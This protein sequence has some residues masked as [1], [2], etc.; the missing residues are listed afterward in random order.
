[1]SKD[2]DISKFLTGADVTNLLSQYHQAHLEKYQPDHPEHILPQLDNSFWQNDK[3]ELIFYAGD[4]TV[5]D[6]ARQ[7]IDQN[8]GRNLYA[9]NLTIVSRLLRY[10]LSTL[11]SE[12]I[13]IIALMNWNNVHWTS[14]V[15]TLKD[16]NKEK[17]SEIY[18]GY[19][20]FKNWLRIHHPTCNLGKETSSTDLFV[21]YVTGNR[22]GDIVGILKDKK[23][24]P[25]EEIEQLICDYFIGIKKEKLLEVNEKPAQYSSYIEGDLKLI[26]EPKNLEDSVFCHFDSMHSESRETLIKNYADR[27]LSANKLGVAHAEL[28]QQSGNT[29][30]EHAVLNALKYV[31]FGLNN[32]IS[33]VDLRTA[34]NYFCSEF[35]RLFLFDFDVNTYKDSFELILTHQKAKA[36]KTPESK[37]DPVQTEDSPKSAGEL[38]AVGV[39]IGVGITLLSI[40]ILAPMAGMATSLSIGLFTAAVGF[41]SAAMAYVIAEQPEEITQ[42]FTTSIELPS[43]AEEE[44]EETAKLMAESLKMAALKEQESNLHENKP[45]AALPVPSKLFTPAASAGKPDA[46]KPDDAPK[47]DKAIPNKP[48][49]EAD[50]SKNPPAVEPKKAKKGKKAKAYP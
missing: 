44:C 12:N 26:L 1:M 9:A 50:V 6:E 38:V 17:Y 43:A 3:G 4:S 37:S 20:A 11:P 36:V 34:S 33:S 18:Q 39:I 46:P 25:K 31:F 21:Q 40:N 8:L 29:C 30:G 48:A 2:Y 28:L 5:Y 47:V 35:A 27:F 15:L 41:V 45:V 10:N 32:T 16:V 7:K 19:Q 23:V 49:V 13:H 14:V 22:H 24:K 42:S